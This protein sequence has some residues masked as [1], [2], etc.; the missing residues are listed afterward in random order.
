MKHWQVWRWVRLLTEEEAKE[1]EQ[2]LRARHPGQAGRQELSNLVALFL[3][4]RRL[5]QQEALEGADWPDVRF[6]ERWAEEEE[7]VFGRK[8]S[9]AYSRKLRSDLAGEVEDFLAARALLGDPL[10]RMLWTV[11]VANRRN[12]PDLFR[13]AF[14][15]AWQASED[16]P[17]RDQEFHS[18]RFELLSEYSI[19]QY[20]QFPA[21]LD[22]M[23]GDF[24]HHWLMAQRYLMLQVGG[25]SVT[26]SRTAPPSAESS[27]PDARA[28]LEGRLLLPV[29]EENE[30]IALHRRLLEASLGAESDLGA[31][32]REIMRL[33][34][35]FSPST[36][37]ALYNW[38]L[39]LFG[40]TTAYAQREAEIE[41]WFQWGWETSVVEIDSI[42]PR[43]LLVNQ[44]FWYAQVE[45]VDAM[46]ECIRYWEQSHVPE[47]KE[48]FI[49]FAR[50]VYQFEQGSVQQTEELLKEAKGIYN[51]TFRH[52]LLDMERRVIYWKASY[53]LG[54]DANEL[55]QEARKVRNWAARSHALS[56]DRRQRLFA[57]LDCFAE[58]LTARSSGQYAALEALLAHASLLPGHDRTWLRRMI[59]RRQ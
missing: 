35:Q 56:E 47:I 13:L 31:L 42:L 19:Y 17:L 46:A 30:G 21:F 55:R 2:Q 36:Q 25:M 32:R 43:T 39:N 44:L 33:W 29:M 27:L 41:A 24:G 51:D 12:Q 10:Q 20:K 53:E 9:P 38:M 49:R 26:R 59:R 16:S 1:C 18:Y 5:R 52:D 54:A 50:R 37:R 45:R 34:P 15:E 22:G 58:L 57:R 48:D 6:S 23:E 4:L 3:L 7:K 28:L 14:Q 40:R 8:L 11:R